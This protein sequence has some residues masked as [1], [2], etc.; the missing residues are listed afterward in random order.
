MVLSSFSPWE[1]WPACLHKT[2]IVEAELILGV[3]SK[4][5]SG[6]GICSLYTKGSINL[7]K[8]YI[9]FAAVEI[10]CD[11]AENLLFR[12]QKDTMRQSTILKY[13]SQPNFLMEEDFQLPRF[14]KEKF[15][16]K[17]PNISKGTYQINEF[18]NSYHL[19]F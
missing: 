8:A 9:N 3:T 14:L 6:N 1:D 16:I 19:F 15:S 7:E 11:A 4:R 13:F 18:K 17:R 2:V 10:E 12:I 5:C